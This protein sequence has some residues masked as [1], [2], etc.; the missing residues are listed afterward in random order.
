MKKNGIIILSLL[1]SFLLPTQTVLAEGLA[2]DISSQIVLYEQ[3]DKTSKISAILNPGVR[4]VP[5]FQQNGWIKVGNPQNGQIGWVN[6]QEYHRAREIFYKPDIQTVFVHIDQSPEGKASLNVVAYKNGNKLTDQQAKALYERLRAQ[7]EAEY[8][9]MQ[10][11]SRQVDDM[12]TRQLTTMH[13]FF[14]NAWR[15]SAHTAPE[16]D[17]GQPL[18]KLNS[19]VAKKEVKA[20]NAAPAL[21][22]VAEEGPVINLNEPPASESPVNEDPEAMENSS[23]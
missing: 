15:S 1:V 21:T 12:V 18:P 20:E 11:F 4:I 9:Q 14:D 17:P 19:P 23:S 10:Q 2:K 22:P 5:V 13:Q 7:Q 16:L 3:P 8:R 6:V